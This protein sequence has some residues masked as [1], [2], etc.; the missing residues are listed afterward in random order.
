MK[1]KEVAEYPG[2]GKVGGAFQEMGVWSAGLAGHPGG[3]SVVPGAGQ[4]S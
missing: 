2:E 4:P 3:L 1:G